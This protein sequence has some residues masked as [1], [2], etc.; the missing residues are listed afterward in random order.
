MQDLQLQTPPTKANALTQIFDSNSNVDAKDLALLEQRV[1]EMERY[2]G[3]ED[4]DL[5]YFYD[6]DGEDLC[7]KT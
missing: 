3:I 4:M 6:Q 1:T 7:K 5:E 2:L